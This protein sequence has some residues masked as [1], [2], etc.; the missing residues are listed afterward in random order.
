MKDPRKRRLSRVHQQLFGLT[1]LIGT[2]PELD[3]LEHIFIEPLALL[4][5]MQQLQ[6]KGTARGGFVFG[7]RLANSLSIHGFA[8]YGPRHHYASF[9][10]GEWNLDYLLGYT[11]AMLTSHAGPV[12]WYGHWYATADAEK[13]NLEEDI[14][15]F[16]AGRGKG[17]FDEFSPFLSVGWR[18]GVLEI[19]AYRTV[20]SE[21]QSLPVTLPR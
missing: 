13:N 8:P 17:L 3:P 12:D 21:I 6:L 5:L 9:N 11:D 7:E 18:E 20:G 10:R 4:S 14:H 15:L 2:E 19:A 16:E 1:Y